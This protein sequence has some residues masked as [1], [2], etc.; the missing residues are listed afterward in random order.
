MPLVGTAQDKIYRPLPNYVQG[1]PNQ[2]EGRKILN[3]FR[4]RGLVADM[5]V[6]FELRVMPKRGEGRVVPARMWLGRNENGP[7]W[8]MELWPED[9]AKEHRLIVQNGPHS[10]LWSWQ[11]NEAGG[12]VTTPGLSG[13]FSR[14]ADTDITP[15]DLQMPFVY[16]NDFVF[17]GLA[18][19]LGRP[20]HVFLLYPPA[21]VARL[22]PELSGVR[23]Y[24]DTQFNALV[25][26][27][28]I[29]AGD[30]VLKTLALRSFKTIDKQTVPKHTDVIDETTRNTTRFAVTRAAVNMDFLPAIFAPDEL[31]RSVEPPQGA[32]LRDLGP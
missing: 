16:W 1:K 18:K 14:L 8:R 13:L 9:T 31:S 3:E 26:T 22:R 29:G 11:R 20:A 28:Q 12:L 32:H 15:F 24:L 5:Y 6:E 10:A 4:Q 2:E 25:K 23:V 7:V 21:E 19:V 30:R 17:E 27:E